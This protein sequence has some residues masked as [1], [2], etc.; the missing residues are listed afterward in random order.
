MSARFVKLDRRT[1]MFLPCDLRE[2]LAADHLV[3]SFWMPWSKFPPATF[4]STTVARAANSMGQD[5]R[6]EVGCFG[7]RYTSIE[8]AVGQDGFDPRRAVG[9][10][11]HRRIPETAEGQMPIHTTARNDNEVVG[12]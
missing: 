6:R 11:P 1:P 9:F 12:S 10:A 2:W 7:R 3:A 8:S 5:E 4:T